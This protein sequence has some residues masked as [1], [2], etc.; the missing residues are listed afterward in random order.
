VLLEAKTAQVK[1]ARDRLQGQFENK[2]FSNSRL[3]V[4]KERI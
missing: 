1:W 3:R 2:L 4:E